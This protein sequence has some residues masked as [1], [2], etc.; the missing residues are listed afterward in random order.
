[1]LIT[2]EHRRFFIKRIICIGAALLLTLSACGNVTPFPSPTASTEPSTTSTVSESIEVDGVTYVPLQSVPDESGIEA[3]WREGQLVLTE[4]GI[5]VTLEAECPY[6]YRRGYLVAVLP[7]SPI[8]KDETMYLSEALSQELFGDGTLLNDILFFKD[9]VATAL[10]QSDVEPWKSIL[11]AVELPRSMN[12]SV[13]NLD[14]DRVFQEKLLGDYPAVLAEEL[15]AMGIENPT[16]YTYSE[17]ILL[18]ESRS[19]EE[20]GLKSFFLDNEALKEENP[21]DWTVR[22]YKDWQQAQLLAETEAGLTEAQREF[23]T[24]KNILLQDI[25]WLKKDFYNSYTECTDEELRE[26]IEAYY[27]MS[28]SYVTGA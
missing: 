14:V 7:S 12:V 8:L 26:T 24:E 3:E 13:P 4:K 25:Q 10:E 2:T 20:A 18:T 23:V 6:L 28:I 27:Q 9:E 16:E 11:A 5:E 22:E 21:A 17:Y 15:I 1:M 19:V